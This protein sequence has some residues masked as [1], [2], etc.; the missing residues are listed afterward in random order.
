MS[1][2]SITGDAGNFTNVTGIAGVFTTS[3]SGATITGDTIQGT[4]GV[5]S[6]LSGSTYTGTTINATT[7]VFQTLAAANLAFTNTVVSGNFSV[8]GSSTFTSGVQ[9]TGTL[10]GTTITGTEVLATTGVFNSITGSTIAITTASG[11]TP[12]L[13]CS[14]VVSGDASGFIIQGPLVILP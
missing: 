8:L 4:S 7:G 12:A 6:S 3:V 9:V 14:G 13:V 11:V 1:G 5:Y 10:S 2:V